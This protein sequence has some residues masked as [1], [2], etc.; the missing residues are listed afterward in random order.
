MLVLLQTNRHK[1]ITVSRSCPF[2]LGIY[3]TIVVYFQRHQAKHVTIMLVCSK[4]YLGSIHPREREYNYTI[5]SHRVP[6][7]MTF[8]AKST[9]KSDLC[10]MTRHV[11]C[12]I[13]I[14]VYLIPLEQRWKSQNNLSFLILSYVWVDQ[15]SISLINCCHIKCE[16]NLVV[17]YAQS[18]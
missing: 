6:N 8:F 11:Q 3:M 18:N 14:G 15:L 7:E 10:L 9:I 5:Y 4:I 12:G 16:N 17:P 1:R 13:W 2:S